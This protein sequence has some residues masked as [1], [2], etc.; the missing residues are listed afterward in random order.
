M[1][2]KT[3]PNISDGKFVKRIKLHAIRFFPCHGRRCVSNSAR[4]QPGTWSIGCRGIKRHAGDGDI[5]AIEIPGVLAP[6]E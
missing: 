1:I 2:E 6:H 3:I 4:S 5:N